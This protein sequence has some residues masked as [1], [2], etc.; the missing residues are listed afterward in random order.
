MVEAP[1]WDAILQQE[2]PRVVPDALRA[3]AL[4]G[5]RKWQWSL[6]IIA[7]ICAPI[8][9]AFFPWSIIDDIR[10]DLGGMAGKG[11]VLKSVYAKRTLGDDAILK[12]RLVFQVHFRFDDDRAREHEAKCLFFEYLRPGTEVDIEYLP[13]IPAVARVRDGFLVPGGLWEAWWSASFIA[14][15]L[16]GFWN[17]RRWRRRRLAL[18]VHGVET[19]G[20]IERAWRDDPQDDTRGWIEVNYTGQ[21]GPIRLSKMVERDIFRRACAIV[22]A[23]K[24]VRLLHDPRIPREHI[25]VELMQ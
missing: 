10:L 8:A 23:R 1:D 13:S 4:R 5:E 21:A 6:V 16:V 14:L 7:I 12:K 19:P 2:P 15:P 9:V 17:Y 11:V 22:E 3:V 20:R 25:I 18:L 24:P